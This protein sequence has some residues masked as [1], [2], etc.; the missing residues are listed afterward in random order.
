MNK[1]LA[2]LQ[3]I[4]GGLAAFATWYLGDK[5]GWPPSMPN[6][7]GTGGIIIT[8]PP[9]DRTFEVFLIIM[10][11]AILVLAMVQIIRHMRLS[12]WQ[13]LGGTSILGISS[14]LFGRTT[15]F[16]YWTESSAY[17]ISYLTMAIGIVVAIIGVIQLILKMRHSSDELKREAI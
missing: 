12:L 11:A 13:I 1:L 5:K 4:L 3:I 14:F 10:G 8:T 17:R 7:D 15:A 9:P 16:T 6:T 2:V